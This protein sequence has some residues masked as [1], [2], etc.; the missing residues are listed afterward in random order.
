M[1]EPTRFRSKI[2]I[3]M[4]A[5]WQDFSGAL[6][7]AWP[8]A[9][10]VVSPDPG[11]H[12]HTP[13]LLIAPTLARAYRPAVIWHNPVTMVLDPGWKPVF[14]RTEGTIGWSYWPARHP[15]I[16]FRGFYGVHRYPYPNCPPCLL[17]TFIDAYCNPGFKEHFNFASRFFRLLGKFASNKN[18]Q[19]VH[20]PSYRPVEY[21]TDKPL[22]GLGPW[23]MVGHHARRWALEDEEHFLEYDPHKKSGLRPTQGS[24]P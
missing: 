10:Y 20:Y 12:W 11:S 17:F 16:L 23:R 13:R 15:Q 18:L 19:E 8:E 24:I 2:A 1:S 3:M 9:R 6:Q 4:A 7:A 14:Y 22:E 5:D 21:P